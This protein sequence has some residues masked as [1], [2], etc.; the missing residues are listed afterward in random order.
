MASSTRA[1]GYTSRSMTSI[2]PVAGL[3]L[4]TWGAI[5]IQPLQSLHRPRSIEGYLFIGTNPKTY[6]DKRGFSRLA[7]GRLRKSGRHLYIF[8]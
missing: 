6:Q 8:L 3:N 7:G 2:N 5:S 4:K 1:T